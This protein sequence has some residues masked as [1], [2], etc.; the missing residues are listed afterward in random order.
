M[1]FVPF[2]KTQSI[3]FLALIIFRL[4]IPLIKSKR[5]CIDKQLE[6]KEY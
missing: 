3:M 4:E 5:E 6:D 1:I 2:H